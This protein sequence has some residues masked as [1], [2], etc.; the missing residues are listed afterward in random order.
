M[1][2]IKPF[3]GVRP[4]PELV[5]KIAAL[6]YDVYNSNEARDIVK[7]NPLSFLQIDRGETLLEEGVGIYD[8][9]VYTA[10]AN[11]LKE[12]ITNKQFIQDNKD[13]YYIYELERLGKVQRGIVGLVQA[14]DYEK[15]IIK[16][17]EN[18]REIKENDRIRH[19]DALKAHTGPIFLTYKNTKTIQKIS[20]DLIA[21]AEVIFEFVSDDD[22][23]HKGYI[24]KDAQKL[25]KVSEF[26][27]LIDTLYIAD[28]HHRAASAAKI[29]K[30]Y[31]YKGECAD[32]LAVI[33]PDEELHILDYNR[34]VEDLNGLSV[35]EFITKVNSSFELVE[36]NE[37][38]SPKEKAT[39]GMYL[40]N[41]WY[42]LK[43]KKYEEVKNDPVASLDVAILQEY[44]LNPILSIKDART[45]DRIGFVG[46][47]R[48]L[49]ELEKRV[50]KDM[51]IAFSLKPTSI[52]E[53]IDVSD[54]DL[55]MPP[56]ST[57]FEPKLRS[58]LFIHLI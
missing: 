50:A 33:F 34:V 46:G 2:V 40:D 3:K 6:P 13:V 56:K 10:A 37:Q 57:W 53:L 18:T 25:D 44:L 55:L 45:S 12:M 43:F 4:A 29:A 28:G 41:K 32:F 39:F 52:H 27:E 42:L 14:K 9:K 15:G 47:I 48:G 31:N 54:A 35:D 5:E 36:M 26:S 30:K 49:G 8:D 38:V 11:K 20:D 23:R 7:G 19:I 51:K 58:G 21:S 22:V 1:T 24:I 17:H 16:K